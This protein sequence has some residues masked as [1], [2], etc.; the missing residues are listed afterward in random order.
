MCFVKM[1]TVEDSVLS[2][3]VH[4][5]PGDKKVSDVRAGA[6]PKSGLMFC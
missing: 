2:G 1:R 4:H 5:A 6:Q 3:P